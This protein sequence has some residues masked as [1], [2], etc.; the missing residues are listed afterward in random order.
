[1]R[2]L[3][4]AV[5]HRTEHWT[6]FFAILAAR[7]E[8]DL[9]LL[10]A[11][12][13]PQTELSLR[14]SVPARDGTRNS[15]IDVPSRALAEAAMRVHVLPHLLGEARTGHMA[16]IAFAPA[17]LRRLQLD[18]PDVVHIIG[19][20]AY[21]STWQLLRWCRQR[22]PGVPVS[23]YAAQNIVTRFPPP[24]PW[25][26]RRAYE[27]VTH[28]LPITPAAL[29]VLRAKGYRGPATI[30][31]LGV[32]IRRF[33][34]VRTQDNDPQL[35]R[36]PH[37]LAEKP[38]LRPLGAANEPNGRFTVGFVGRLEPHKG[39]ATLLAAIEPLD[40]DLLVVGRGSLSPSVQAAAARNPGRITIVDWADHQQLPELLHR[41]NV[42]ALPSTEVVQ[43][44]VLPWIG[45][46]LREQFGRVLVEA[47]ACGVPV[48]GSNLGEIRHVVGSAG[49][50]VPPDDVAALRG[51]IARLRNDP[52]L[53]RRLSAVGISRARDE[54]SWDRAAALTIDVWRNLTTTQAVAVGNE[55]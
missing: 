50:T 4:T 12:V 13:S 46:P 44:N 32:D 49:L 53:A 51:A 10:L 30:V 1:M 9:T 42:L 48:I 39:V 33:R 37:E 6:D 54:F 40:V 3:I 25:L 52:G 2:V 15:R 28:A 38:P 5:G 29:H 43:R 26:E 16:S 21:L 20:A 8:V 14:D 55:R 7:P 23:L 11:D 36:R 47:M 31:P 34:P 41:M 18:R 27:A 35:G 19:E 24:F 17:A 45:I 22:W